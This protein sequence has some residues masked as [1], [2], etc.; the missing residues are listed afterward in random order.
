MR[1]LIFVAVFAIVGCGKS[2]ANKCESLARQAAVCDKVASNQ[3]AD[4]M[5]TVV[6]NCIQAASNDPNH[7]DKVEAYMKYQCK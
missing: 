1:T 3:M 4:Y 6:M 2:I 7:F 5:S